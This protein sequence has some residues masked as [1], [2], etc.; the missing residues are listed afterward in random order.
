[1][2]AFVLILVPRRLGRV[3]GGEGGREWEAEWLLA[4]TMGQANNSAVGH[5]GCLL[6]L[7][8]PHSQPPFPP[9]TVS[10]YGNEVL[11]CIVKTI[12][13]DLFLCDKQ[14]VYAS[15]A[16]LTIRLICHPK[17]HRLSLLL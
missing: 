7:L 8:P 4:P 15:P 13:P 12:S 2:S 1:M 5:P 3:C 6:S 10:D 16:Y 9:T 11:L 14:N 17:Y